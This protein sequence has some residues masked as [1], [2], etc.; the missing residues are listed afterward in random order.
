MIFCACAEK[1]R[2]WATKS[3]DLMKSY[4]SLT[5]VRDSSAPLSEMML[6]FLEKHCILFGKT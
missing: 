4:A 3:V 6:M 2:K 5:D 1:E